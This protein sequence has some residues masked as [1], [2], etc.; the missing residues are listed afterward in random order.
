MKFGERVQALMCFRR[1]AALSLRMEV[2]SQSV[3]N[4]RQLDSLSMVEKTHSHLCIPSDLRALH[5]LFLENS[6]LRTYL[7]IQK[8]LLRL[9]I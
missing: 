1:R 8:A 2:V 6:N 4:Q 3:H 7:F 9:K 5:Q